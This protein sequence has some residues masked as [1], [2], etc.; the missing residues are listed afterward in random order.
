MHNV[1]HQHH[2]S[3][4]KSYV[5]LCKNVLHCFPIVLLFFAIR[6]DTLKSTG[7]YSLRYKYTITSNASC[8]LY[9]FTHLL[10]RLRM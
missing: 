9:F 6:V 2:I 10:S 4:F 1:S 8:V 5:S 7:E 3:T